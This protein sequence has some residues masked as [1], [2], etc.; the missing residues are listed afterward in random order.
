MTFESGIHRV[1]VLD[2]EL[3]GNLTT[4]II[5]VVNDGASIGFLPPLQPA[6]AKQ[7][8]EE[9]MSPGVILWVTM[10]ENEVAGT[11]QLHL[12]Q[13]QNASHRAE[14]AKLMVHPK[15][16]R[17]GIARALMTTAEEEAK[18]A[19]RSLIV[20]DTRSGDPSNN[21]YVSMDYI[22]AGHIP[23]YA[24]SAGGAF[25]GTTFYYKKFS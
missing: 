13:K 12:A 17:H 1:E 19:G 23:N 9:V 22:P 7:Y 11:I 15:Y 3:L 4:L 24:Q 25:D 8:W 10:I 16:R 14:V 21:L 5:D 6:D 18:L 20:L 2:T